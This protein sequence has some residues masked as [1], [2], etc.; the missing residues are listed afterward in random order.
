[1]EEIV[2]AEQQPV[3]YFAA[4]NAE[5]MGKVKGGLLIWV[6]GRK[7][8]AETDVDDLQS[9]VDHARKHK[10]ATK[11]LEYQLGKVKKLKTYYDKVYAALEQGYVLIPAFPIDVFAIRTAK[12][13]PKRNDVTVK[14]YNDARSNSAVHSELLPAGE[15]EYKSDEARR[16]QEFSY[17]RKEKEYDGKEVEKNYY[18]FYNEEFQ[19]ITFPMIAAKP[20]V[21]NAT[22]QAMVLKIFDEI[23]ISTKDAG[24]HSRNFRRGDPLIIGTIYGPGPRW[25]RKQCHFLIAWHVNVEDI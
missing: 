16:M 15:G 12:E 10:W 3:T 19:D 22:T 23:G 11:T 25:S 18:N 14:E 17:S 1:M 21:M 6:E 2:K 7:R 9:A 4:T 13:N 20:D 24:E 8:H 5:E